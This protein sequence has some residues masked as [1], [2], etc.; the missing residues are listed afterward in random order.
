VPIADTPA[1]R[2]RGLVKAFGEQL[3][4]D[5][6]DLDVPAGGVLALLGPSGSGKTTALRVIAG[7]E[8]PDS[9][10]V[11][12]D[13]RQ[14]T[15]PAG[16]V[17]PERR[18]IGMV[19]QHAALFPHLDVGANVAYGL[20]ERSE[21]AARVAEVLDLVGLAGAGTRM[22]NELSGGE[23]QRVALA[24]ALAP[25]PAVVLLDEPFAGLDAPQRE[26][27]RREVRAILVEAGA[28]A[29]FVTHDQEEALSTS[30]G[31]AV[32]RA[33][34]VVQ[35]G[36]PTEVYLRPA[37]RWVARFLGEAEFLPGTVAGDGI[38][39]T[40]LG[41]LPAVTSLRGD[42]EVMIRPEAVRLRRD[43]NGAARVVAREFFGHDQLLTLDVGGRRLLA[44]T[45]P[46]PHIDEGDRV[47]VEVLETVVFPAADTRPG[48]P[49]GPPG[50]RSAS[51]GSALDR[52]GEDPP[53]EVALQREEHQQ[54]HHD[55]HE[56]G[57]EP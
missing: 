24:R 32:M 37:D 18:R 29:L 34:R 46:L 13:G 15:G 26:R 48:G 14:V 33:G 8:A 31:V 5:R 49:V 20:A 12:I 28:T 51:R 42:V 54:R 4:L 3:A 25:R 9:G 45:G 55:R 2:C 57:G 19:F 23:Q 17:P 36:T 40:P 47:E 56:G 21:R 11:E 1:I 22:P 10:T 35:R 43:G 30:D 44:R 27:V 16:A 53:H 6:F 52:P 39:E 50:R 38:V 7:F 41:R